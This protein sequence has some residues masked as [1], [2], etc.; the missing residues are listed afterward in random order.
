MQMEIELHAN[1]TND[2]R[3][4]NETKR[5]RINAISFVGTHVNRCKIE[6]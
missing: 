6:L 4:D 5:S 3:S 1:L 2:N